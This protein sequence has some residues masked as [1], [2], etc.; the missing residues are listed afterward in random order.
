[1][2]IR[3]RFQP[4]LLGG[5]GFVTY[6]HLP[7]QTSDGG[8]IIVRDGIVQTTNGVILTGVTVDNFDTGWH[9]NWGWNAGGGLAWRFANKELF[10]ESR[11]LGFNTNHNN[12][13]NNLFP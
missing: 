1:M 6:D 2:C 11:V 12:N 10:V 3:D 9:T 7:L 5:G 8:F 4:Y 13:L